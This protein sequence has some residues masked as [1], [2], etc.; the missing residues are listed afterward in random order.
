[1][2]CRHFVGEEWT[3]VGYEDAKMSN[4]V[5]TIKRAKQLHWNV[6]DDDDDGSKLP[7]TGDFDEE[8]L[9]VEAAH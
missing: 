9:W 5:E 7:I 6:D 8:F 2:V 1:M 3:V 4:A